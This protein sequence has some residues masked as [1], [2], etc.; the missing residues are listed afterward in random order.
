MPTAVKAPDLNVSHGYLVPHGCSL[1][2]AMADIDMPPSIPTNNRDATPQAKV[3]RSQP[4]NLLD[5]AGYAH[6]LGHVKLDR[7]VD[8]IVPAFGNR[9]RLLE[10]SRWFS[11]SPS[12]TK[13]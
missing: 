4:Q 7:K 9:T 3:F 5:I 11:R 10:Y 6:W 2:P 1:R 13:L 12:L 8:G